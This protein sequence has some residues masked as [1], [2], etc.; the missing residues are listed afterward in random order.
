LLE[1]GALVNQVNPNG[2]TPLH[3]AAGD[4]SFERVYD[5]NGGIICVSSSRL[6]SCSSGE[7]PAGEWSHHGCPR[8]RKNE[9]GGSIQVIQG[10]PV[11]G[12]CPA[13]ELK[14]LLKVY[15]HPAIHVKA[16]DGEK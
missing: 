9:A 16:R 6:R 12:N 1:K 10:G 2:S 13:F 3:F 4:P 14:W 5:E 7:G 8:Q 15:L 11:G